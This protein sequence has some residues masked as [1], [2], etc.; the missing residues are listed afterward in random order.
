MSD[1]FGV[2]LLKR[3]DELNVS[4]AFHNYIY[5]EIHNHFTNE[6][7]RYFPIFGQHE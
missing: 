2:K 5:T 6:M 1:N 3:E 7:V 4:F